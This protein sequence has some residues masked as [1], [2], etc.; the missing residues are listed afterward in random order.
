MPEYQPVTTIDQIAA[1]VSDDTIAG[2]G[3]RKV[4]LGYLTCAEWCDINSDHQDDLPDDWQDD[5]QGWEPTTLHES[6]DECRQ[7]LCQIALA[8]PRF[9]ELLDELGYDGREDRFGHDFWLTRNRHGVGFWD[10]SELSEE[11]PAEFILIPGH[12]NAPHPAYPPSNELGN[13]SGRAGETVGDWL[14]RLAKV[15]GETYAEYFADSKTS[16]VYNG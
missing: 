7:L 2:L 9:G 6:A 8:V 10:R 11:C 16:A 14:S 12:D 15:Y 3:L 4:L 5:W 1:H 13:V